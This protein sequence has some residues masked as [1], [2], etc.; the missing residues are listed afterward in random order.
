MAGIVGCLCFFYNHGEATR[1]MWAPALRESFS[2]PFHLLQMIAVFSFIQAKQSRHVFLTLSTLIYMLPWQFGQFS[3]GT[4]AASIFATYSLGFLSQRKLI[5]YIA[6]QTLALV[7]CFILMFG[8]R[9]LMT[10]FFASLLVSVWVIIFFEKLIELIR[11][12]PLKNPTSWL[13]VAVIAFT[14]VLF[15]F[16]FMFLAKKYFLGGL[17]PHR[18]DSHIW[19]ILKSKFDPTFFT[20]DTRLYTCAA[21]FDF[22]ELGT[23]TKFS[24]TMLL[25]TALLVFMFYLALVLKRVFIHTSSAKELNPEDPEVNKECMILYNLFQLIAYTIMA[26]LI[27]RLKLFWTPHLCIFASYIANKCAEHNAVL[28]ISSLFRSKLLVYKKEV[29]RLL[30]VWCVIASMSRQ[31]ISNLYEQQSRTDEFSELTMEGMMTW[32][33]QNTLPNDVFVGSMAIMANVKLSTNRPVVNHPH[34]EDEGLRNRTKYIYSFMYG[35]REVKELNALLKN[36]YRASY[37]II[38]THLCASAP[39]G[40][41]ECGMNQV[42]H[43]GFGRRTARRACEVIMKQSEATRKHFVQVYAQNYIYIFIIV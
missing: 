7:L 14:R 33:S 42:A 5:G 16:V 12:R 8:N 41:P 13:Q 28:K 4:Q 9:M 22:L 39:P 10:S 40:K 11:K 2:F 32:I 3:L 26:G 18:D 25:P 19:D 35:N 43:I 20:F 17:F 15:L 37:L 31:G 1:V 30:I 29:T 23:V 24:Q 21:E 34:Y 38:E 6:C 36:E 27:M